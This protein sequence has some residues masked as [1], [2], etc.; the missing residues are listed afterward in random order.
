MK[1]LLQISIATLLLGASMC[2]SSSHP[3]KWSDKELNDWFDSGKFLN[4]LQMSPDQSIDRR[5]FAIH[6]YDHKVIWDKAFAFLKSAD[7]VNAPLGRIELEGDLF[8]TVSEYFPKD[9]EGT[10][11]E[12]HQKYIDI[13]FII[14][15]K[16]LMDVAPLKNVTITNLYDPEIE[17]LFGTVPSFST[18]K[19]SP[20]RLFIFFPDDAHRPSMKDG[21]D[22]IFVR[23]VVV[24]VPK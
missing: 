21:I 20:G 15:G 8:A 22:S 9:R 3:T 23:K 13:Q 10:L 11:F 19:A 17:A 24:K 1:T 4:G 5:S 6:Y 14:A 18:L 2:N 12:A 16:E 7:L